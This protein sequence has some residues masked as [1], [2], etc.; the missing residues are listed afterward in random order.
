MKKKAVTILFALMMTASLLAGCG[1]AAAVDA[2]IGSTETVQ[3]AEGETGE[4]DTEPEATATPDAT[5]AE[6]PEAEA[7]AEPA[8]TTE[9]EATAE[10]ADTV[11]TQTA[12]ESADATEPTA[13]EAAAT[14]TPE[15]EPVAVVYTYTDMNQTMWAKSSVNVRDLPSTDGNKVSSL[16]GGQEVTVTGRCNETGWYRLE[17]GNYVSGNYLVAEKPA[18][19]ATAAGTAEGSVIICSSF[20]E[21]E[22]LCDMGDSIEIAEDGTIS[23]IKGGG[24]AV[25]AGTNEWTV[26]SSRD[27]INYLNQ[28]R[29]EQGLAA[30]E[31]DSTLEA[32]AVSRAQQ[33]ASDYSHNGGSYV[34][35]IAEIYSDPLNIE[36]WYNAWYNSEGHRANMFSAGYVKAACAYYT[37]GS[38]SYVITVFQGDTSPA[39]AEQLQQQVDSGEMTIINSTTDENTGETVNVY[40]TPGTKTLE[41]AVADG[42]ITQEEAD[43]AQEKADEAVKKVNDLLNQ[44]YSPEEVAAILNGGN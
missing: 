29:A 5:A 8:A 10:P 30:L 42:D 35:N 32:N 40:A 28:K 27:F 19:T 37:N 7:A 39:S 16:K 33:L 9:P 6:E 11:D 41:Q 34:E 14:A 12:A 38:K 1:N 31:W 25:L 22:A 15:T 21:A 3:F 43:R 36:A 18:V 4:S 2:E 23:V 44:G 20:E 13:A 24:A 26:S 17:N